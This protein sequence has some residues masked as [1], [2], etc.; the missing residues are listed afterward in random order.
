VVLRTGDTA[1]NAN[2]LSALP[3]PMP[4]ATT[5]GPAISHRGLRR[6]A[7]IRVGNVVANR[8]DKGERGSFGL[9]GRTRD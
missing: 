2:E 4:L 1:W 7:S 9:E 6:G 8:P 3:I 5:C